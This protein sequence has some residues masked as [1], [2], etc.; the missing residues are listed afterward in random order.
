M[1]AL[2][3]HNLHIQCLSIKIDW[4]DKKLQCQEYLDIKCKGYR[5]DDDLKK[6]CEERINCINE[7]KLVSEMFVEILMILSK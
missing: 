5:T 4:D 7:Q 1:F 3:Q 2:C 6:S